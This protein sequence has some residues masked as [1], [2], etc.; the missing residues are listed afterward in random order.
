MKIEIITTGGTIDK[1]YFDEFNQYEVGGPSI[2]V[3]IDELRLNASYKFNS[4]I[5]KDSLFLTDKDR[6]SIVTAVRN[7]KQKKI[8]ITHG[9]DTMVET[10]K[11]LIRIKQKAIVLTGA[12]SPSIFKNTD[13]VF[14]VGFAL[15]SLMLIDQGTF[16]AMNGML[17][18]PNN[19]CKNRK[20]GKFEKIKKANL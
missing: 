5:K 18:D 15:G 13:A 20:T 14:N 8:L 4:I 11:K 17:F 2:K 7:S 19:V 9:T 6:E 3:L 10:A 1:I 12:T 16:I